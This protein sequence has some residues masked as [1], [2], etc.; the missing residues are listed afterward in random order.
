MAD[1]GED[2]NLELDNKLTPQTDIYFCGNI[3]TCMEKF[4]C[5]ISNQIYVIRE[6]SS[7]F[8]KENI[9]MLNSKLKITIISLGQ[10]PINVFGLGVYFRNGFD[11]RLDIFDSI[12]HSHQFQSLRE[13]NK[14][15]DA[16][17]T[18][19]YISEVVQTNHTEQS[20]NSDELEFH[21]LRCSTNL[22]GGTDNLR[23]IDKMICEKANVWAEKFFDSK[24]SLN[25]IL[26][27]VY[28]NSIFNHDNNDKKEKKAKIK[29]HSDKTKD[30]PNNGLMAFCSFYQNYN[31]IN[32][33]LDEKSKVKKSQT[34]L[35][36]YVYGGGETTVLTKLRFRLKSD[37]NIDTDTNMD[38]T[39]LVKQFDITLYP[40]S[41]FLM[42][43]KTNRLYTHEIIPSG[44]PVG[45]I[46]TRMGY[47][48]RCSNTKAIY[49][50]GKTWI[51]SQTQKFKTKV[52]VE[53][54]KQP[55]ENEITELKNLY[56]NQNMTSKKIVYDGFNFSLNKGDYMKPM[57]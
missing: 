45:I 13:S 43:L 18:G 2:F 33:V 21:L 16:F 32:F 27:Q 22:S 40:N 25:H 55:N 8:A 47:V 42:S 57:I 20:I 10:V 48:I 46:P 39:S 7:N 12:V 11:S 49:K 1:N 54:E 44:L 17:R 5:I 23:Q 31:G 4:K 36:D 9:N 6:L 15:T 41:I 35:F 28:T 14:P 29:T 56:F 51:E 3:Q 30:M 19:I 38:I 52:L 24:T 37:V 26:A 34:D 50:D 53:L